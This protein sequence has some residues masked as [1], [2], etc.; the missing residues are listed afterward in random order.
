MFKWFGGKSKKDATVPPT[1]EGPLPVEAPKEQP[2]ASSGSVS[3]MEKSTGQAEPPKSGFS[4]LKAAVSLTGKALVDQVMG[5]F[6]ETELDDDA[7]DDIEEALVRADVGLSTAVEI[8]DRIRANR[9]QIGTVEK[10]RAFLKTEFTSILSPYANANQLQFEPGKLNIYLVVGVNG[11]GKTTFIGKLARRY[12][13]QGKKVVIGAGD[14]FRAAAEEQLDVWAQRAGAEL[15]R[16]DGSD[17][18]AVIF[19]TL[20]HAKAQQA[21]VVLLDTA[22]RLQNK[23]NLME[24]LRKIRKVIEKAKP[25]GAVYESLLVLDATTGQN[26]LKQAEVFKEAVD[27]SGVVLT[28]L[29]S[30]A[31]GGVILSIAKEFHLPVKLVG[32]GEGIED[33]KDFDTEEFIQALFPSDRS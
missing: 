30:S 33:L 29:D 19:D 15:I 31:K 20:A 24:E 14:T 4:K 26:A 5:A 23:Y 2:P 18:A 13:Q 21:D 3:T 12:V 28:K 16:K 7:V 11:A 25:E 10:L 6:Q 22:G 17:A 32:V 9:S 27:L 1:S 8:T